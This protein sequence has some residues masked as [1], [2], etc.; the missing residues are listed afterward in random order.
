MA[1]L[2]SRQ[3]QQVVPP[4]CPSSSPL[5]P[6]LPSAVH[7]LSL[8]PAGPASPASGGQANVCRLSCPGIMYAPPLS[9]TNTGPRVTQ[10]TLTIWPSTGRCSTASQPPPGPLPHSLLLQP[11]PSSSHSDTI[12][13]SPSPSCPLAN[14]VK[15][16]PALSQCSF[17][18]S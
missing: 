10:S 18:L 16:P 4:L 6:S 1:R 11:P 13:T 7:A 3:K 14:P 2:L 17:P 15:C 5:R 9:N 12:D 8:P